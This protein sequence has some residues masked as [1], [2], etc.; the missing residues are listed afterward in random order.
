MIRV[1]FYPE[2]F[3]EASWELIE[4]S[5]DWGGGFFF[6]RFYYL[7][8]RVRERVHAQAVGERKKQALR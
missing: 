7:F 6:L 4:P 8:A 1:L 5:I 3:T 2:D